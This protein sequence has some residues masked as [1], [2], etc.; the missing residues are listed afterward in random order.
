MRFLFVLP[1]LILSSSCI[2][3]SVPSKIDADNLANRINSSFLQ[4]KVF[5]DTFSF[6]HSDTGGIHKSIYYFGCNGE[7][8]KVV[9][10]AFIFPLIDFATKISTSTT[11]FFLEKNHAF[12]HIRKPAADNQEITYLLLDDYDRIKIQGNLSTD[13]MKKKK[14]IETS[15]FLL[16]LYNAKT[17]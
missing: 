9:D 4:E 3:Q 1:L 8:V 5:A 15:I 10:S 2:C 6:S 11:I 12:K 13:L 17:P 7:C 16:Q 14:I